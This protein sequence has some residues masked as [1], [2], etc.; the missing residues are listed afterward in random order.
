MKIS[1]YVARFIEN[2]GTEHVFLITGGAVVHLVDS[3]GRRMDNGGLRYVC[4]QHEQAAAMASEAY[5]R[6]S[7]KGM[8]VSIVTSGP[9][10]TNLITG[11]CGCWYDSIP[12]LFISGQ[13]NNKE[14]LDSVRAVP[15]QVGFQETDIVSIVA[16]IT[17]FAE[18]VKDPQ[19]I[20]FVL[21]KAIF[22][23][24]SGRPGPVV[25]DL[26]IDV[27]FADIDPEHLQGFIP[28]IDK[29][30]H[31]G[32]DKREVVRSALSM[33]K[34]AKRPMVILGAG[35]RSSECLKETI[36]LVEKLGAPVA[37][38]WGAFDV[39]AHDH[40]LFGGHLGIYG[41]RGTNFAV[42]NADLLLVLGSRLDT[43]QTGAIPKLFAR[44]AKKIVVDIDKNELQKGRGLHIDL[45]IN[46]D[47]REIVPIF[48]EEY[49]SG[50]RAS[51]DVRSWVAKVIALKE[52]YR[53]ENATK[54]ESPINAYD[55][56]EFLSGLA[57][58]GATIIP[59]EGGN[60]V[61]T[62]QA[63]SVKKGQRLFSTFG[64][65]PLGY[66]FPAAIGASFALGRRPVI[67]IDGDGGFQM[68]IQELQTVK[69]YEIP[70]KIFVLNN[71][72][73]GI[74]KQFQDM[75]FDGRYEASGRGYSVPDL[76]KVARAYG[77]PTR[78][79]K[80]MRSAKR[81]IKE[82]LSSEGPFFC[83]VVVDEKQKLNPKLEFGRPLEDMFPYL[84]DPEFFENMI[85][86]PLSREKES[87]WKTI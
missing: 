24:K 34:A 39:L 83:N 29:A 71:N 51:E 9:G 21:E 5:S 2:L 77:I 3:I 68:N 76:T 75:Y 45:P 44:E 52:R 11:I 78:T 73:Y 69:H 87:K 64:N 13:V 48:L 22:L 4:F 23:A 26:P 60:L 28:P 7:E 16:P 46:A 56:I 58:E 47:L 79:I 61:W 80:N 84:D 81:T 32:E 20:R 10:A 62:M 74:I 31:E 65:S 36:Q 49:S 50:E 67:C 59:D 53:R 57:P 25:V 66:A 70:L 40:P 12:A 1:D 15:R 54:K 18:K 41:N 85:I 86:A 43:R 33:I 35:V 82:I 6:V 55:F 8:G 30:T 19:D 63:W 42:Q 38:S 37:V 72:G 14:S 17:K 27:Q